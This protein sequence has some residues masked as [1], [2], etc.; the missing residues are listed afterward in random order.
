MPQN[1]LPISYGRRLSIA[2]DCY[3]LRT[4][5]HGGGGNST[6]TASSHILALQVDNYKSKKRCYEI[7][8]GLQCA[9]CSKP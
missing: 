8:L 4:C 5:G 1:Y 9:S 7:N 2:S 6:N 3:Y